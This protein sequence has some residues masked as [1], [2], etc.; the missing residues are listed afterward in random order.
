MEDK[1]EEKAK[2]ILNRQMYAMGKDATLRIMKSSVLV[3]GARGL[4]AEAAKNLIL[5]GVGALTLYDPHPVAAEDLATH[6]FLTPADVGKPRASACVERFRE[7]SFS[8]TVAVA[9]RSPLQDAALLERHN[10]V[11]LAGGTLG[12]ALALD[13]VCRTARLGGVFAAD[14]AFRSAPEHPSFVWADARGVFAFV[15]ND[16]GDAFVV[17]DANGESPLSYMVSNIT[18][19]AA[20]GVV[21][22]VEEARLEL[23]TGDRVTFAGLESAPGLVGRPIAIKDV[24]GKYEFRIDEDTSHMP[25]FH[26]S[27]Y[28]TEVKTPKPH[29]FVPL[30]RSV[31]DPGVIEPSDFSKDG[32]QYLLLLAFRALWRFAEARAGALP[33]VHNDEDA[34]ELLKIVEALNAELPEARRAKV[35]PAVVRAL[36]HVARGELSPM[37]TFVGGVACQEVLKACS[38]KYTPIKQWLFFDAMEALP[39]PATPAAEFMPIGSRYDAQVAVIGRAL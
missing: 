33:R 31:L 7:L 35:E 36:A 2:A 9:E 17:N 26:G 20:G 29:A 18:Q 10:V 5:M 28:V 11:L 14:D 21:S 19:D 24:T 27:G 34:A 39:D 4:G 13:A 15:Y 23:A 8:A 25:L 32:R 12:E 16:L 22:I 38:G 30:A 1:K 37:T 3:V 6:F